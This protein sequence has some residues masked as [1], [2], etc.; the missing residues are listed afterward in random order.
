MNTMFAY[1]NGDIIPLEDVKISPFDRGFLFSDGIYEVIRY[2]PLKLFQITFHLDRLK[3]SLE[4]MKINITKLDFLEPTIMELFSKNNLL[5]VPSIAY[6]QITR[7]VQFPRRH[8]YAEELTPTVFI[9][10]VE[11]PVKSKI[12]NEGIKAGL[13][14]DVRWLRCDIKSISLI[15]N[16]AAKQR[17]K[18]NGFGET[19]FHRNGFVTE[20]THSNVC[21]VKN[22]KVVTPPL[23]NLILHGV[24]R[25]TVLELCKEPEIEVEEREI[26]VSELNNF[27]EAFMLA[28]T[29]GVVPVVEIA[30]TKVNDG[31]P[32]KITRILQEAYQKLITG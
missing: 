8:D 32:G 24:T 15:A 25:R 1:F 19:I 31:K 16:T 20:G 2:Y 11:L 7:G 26:P 18:E 5:D 29:T 22:R 6:L 21:F 23:S 3:S 17:A 12:I 9:Y 28:T 10:T 13:E 4:K 30:G 14:E 27:D